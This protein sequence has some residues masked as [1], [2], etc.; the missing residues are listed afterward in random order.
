MICCINIVLLTFNR[1]V[2]D[3]E[4]QSV[5]HLG[6]IARKSCLPSLLPPW[7]ASNVTCHNPFGSFDKNNANPAIFQRIFAVHRDG[8]LDSV[9]V[10]ADGPKSLNSNRCAFVINH[11]SFSY[12]LH[13]LFSVFTADLIVTKKA[14]TYTCHHHHHRFFIIYTDFRSLRMHCRHFQRNTT[15]FHK[16]WI[17]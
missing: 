15:A 16:S 4:K 10:H 1:L 12:R 9:E 3:W 11:N 7:V 13:S 2:L 5:D 6:D 17:F 14:V 8:Y